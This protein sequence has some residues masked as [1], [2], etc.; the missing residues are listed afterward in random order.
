MHVWIPFPCHVAVVELEF[1]EPAVTG[2]FP[3][4]YHTQQEECLGQQDNRDAELLKM[5][6]I[7]Q[8]QCSSKLERRRIGQS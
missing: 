5:E 3:H 1:N 8:M 7:P 4:L 2:G 6:G